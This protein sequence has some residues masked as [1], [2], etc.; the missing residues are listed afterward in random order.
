MLKIYVGRSEESFRWDYFFFLVF[1]VMFIDSIKL[2][3]IILVSGCPFILE[4]AA[5]PK[6]LLHLKKKQ[7]T[8]GFGS[9]FPTTKRMTLVVGNQLE[10]DL[11]Y[12]KWP[13]GVSISTACKTGY[14]K[15]CFQKVPDLNCQI[16]FVQLIRAVVTQIKKFI[17]KTL[18]IK[19]KSIRKVIGKSVPVVT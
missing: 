18:N 19:I 13:H 9:W 7:K 16:W 6:R 10:N 12:L 15:A 1:F 4:G 14:I 2:F 8:Q 3:H 5:V 17:S 11:Q